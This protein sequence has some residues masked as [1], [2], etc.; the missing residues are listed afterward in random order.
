MSIERHQESIGG[1]MLLKESEVREMLEIYRRL[2][3]IDKH[4]LFTSAAILLASKQVKPKKP[5]KTAKNGTK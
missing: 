3:Q 5:K 1:V 4:I 2:N